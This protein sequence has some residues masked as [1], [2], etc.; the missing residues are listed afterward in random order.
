MTLANQLTLAR[1]LLGVL[2]FVCLWLRTPGAF[3]AALALYTAATITD[4]F[5]G[6]VARRT[7]TVSVFGALADPIADKILVIGALIAFLRIPSLNI[8]AW[9]VFVIIVRDFIIGGLRTLAGAQGKVLAAE[10]WGK[11]KMGVQ[12]FC[13]LA[14]LAYLVARDTYEMRMPDW[15]FP[16]PAYLVSL[17]AVVT[18]ASAVPYLTK[19]IG[20]LQKSWNPKP[21]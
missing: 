20:L 11:F 9:A 5:D 8:P 10:R 15:I 1:A 19:N 21:R 18:V 12:S 4:W 2:T 6:W 17:M 13:V 3:V 14:V 16:I 7:E